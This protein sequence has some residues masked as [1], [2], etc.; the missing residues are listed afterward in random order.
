M[1][2]KEKASGLE[3]NWMGVCKNSNRHAVSKEKTE[4]LCPSPQESL[5]L[6]QES[7]R[8]QMIWKSNWNLKGEM[9]T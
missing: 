7:S 6:D 9:M 2:K 8:Y 4:K 1:Q 3:F 5:L